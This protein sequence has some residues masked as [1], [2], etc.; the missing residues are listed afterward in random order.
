MGSGTLK[1]SAVRRCRKWGKKKD[2][3]RIN[4]WVRYIII[5]ST[6][7]GNAKRPHRG[8]R[9]GNT[10]ER[11]HLP[12]SLR[13]RKRKSRPLST[14]YN[15]GVKGRGG[16]NGKICQCPRDSLWLGREKRRERGRKRTNLET[17]PFVYVSRSHRD[18]EIEKQREMGKKEDK[19]M[20]KVLR[21]AVDVK[22]CIKSRRKSKRSNVTSSAMDPTSGGKLLKTWEGKGRCKEGEEA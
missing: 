22:S 12:K 1:L 3:K 16:E 13:K 6:G 7:K 9:G 2:R 20:L 11:G 8:P 15:T 14:F 17:R 10:R 18:T 4:E 5:Y 19:G 21:A